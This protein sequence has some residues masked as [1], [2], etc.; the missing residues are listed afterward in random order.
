MKSKIALTKKDFAVALA[1]VAFLLMTI[2]ATTTSGRKRAKE[3]VCLS[4]LRQWAVTLQMHIEDND[5]YFFTGEGQSGYWWI[6]ELKDQ[7]RDWKSMKAWFCPEAATPLVDE[8]GRLTNRQSVF[9]AWGIFQGPGLG[10]NG[11]AGSY[12]LNGYVLAIPYNGTYE[13]GVPARDGWRTPDTPGASNVPL[14]LDALRFDLFPSYMNVPPHDESAPW[15]SNHMA[16]CCINR[17][18]GAVECLF[19]DFSARKVALKQLWTLKWH[20]SFNTTGP[21]TKAGGVRPMDWPRWM[22]GF[23]E[24]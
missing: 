14:F 3:A 20:K 18:H 2:G 6:K 10:P 11:I 5:G 1:C 9:S 17:H 15:S 22:S 19:M 4:N 16:R 12:G 7:Y 24:Y 13:G 8:Y 21:W 23:K